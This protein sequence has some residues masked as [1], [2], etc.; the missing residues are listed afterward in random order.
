MLGTE[1]VERFW[2]DGF[3]KGGQVLTPQEVG[4][5][6]EEMERVIRDVGKKDVPQPVRCVNLN[7]REPAA[8]VWQ[9]VNIWQAS[10]PFKRLVFNPVVAGEVA[11]LLDA[12]ELR[13]WHDQ[14][15]YKPSTAGGVNMWHQDWPYW[16]ILSE[17]AQVTAWIALDDVD[18]E[19]GCM[20]MVRGSHRWGNT[21][22]FLHSLGQD[23]GAMPA[24]W[25]G[26]AVEVVTCPV[27]AGQVHFHHGLTW[28]GS[29]R[30]RSIRKRRAIALHFMSERTRYNASG[31]HIMKPFVRVGDGEVMSGEVFPLVWSAAGVR[32]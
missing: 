12:R 17:P 28:H 25:N 5:L 13:L 26:H 11:Q 24:Q 1:Q 10:E 30:N 15:Q 31:N 2:R 6:Q 27:R 20:S 7:Q 22:E 16:P 4:E 32:V 23:F 9:I 19:N 8:P 14:I 21:I 29:G 18:E 3:L